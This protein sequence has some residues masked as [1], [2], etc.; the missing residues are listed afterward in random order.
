MSNITTN[1]QGDLCQF[2]IAGAPDRTDVRYVWSFWD[3][4]IETTVA[5]AIDKIVNRIGNLPV[6]VTMVGPR[7]QNKTF[8]FTV[9]GLSGP[10]FTGLVVP[11]SSFPVP[12]LISLAAESTDPYIPISGAWSDSSGNPIATGPYLQVTE[13]YQSAP[14]TYTAIDEIGTVE[15]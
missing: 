14:F 11:P 10:Q 6:N 13:Q 5:P 3:G 9:G 2:T 12:R 15:T 7:G 1:R 4:D 8:N